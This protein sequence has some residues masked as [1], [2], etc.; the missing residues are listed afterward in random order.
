MSPSFDSPT[1]TSSQSNRLSVVVTGGASGIGLAVTSYFASQG[2]MVAVLDVNSKTGPDEIAR[3]AK[4]YP[5]S[6]ITFKW[7]DVSS[8]EGQYA[9][10]DQV[11]RE[12]G[13]R[14]DIAIAN[15][16]ISDPVVGALDCTPTE[17]PRKPQLR[18]QDINLNG[19]IYSVS[20]AV[21]YML[22]NEIGSRLPDSR[23][24]IVC[25][26][27]SAAFYPFPVSPLYS[28][29][30]AGIVGLVRSMAVRLEEP[31]IQI[32]AL[33]PGALE[34]NIAPDKDLFKHMVITPMSTLIKAVEQFVTQPS[35]T[36]EV[37][38]LNEETITMRPP[39]EYAN[40]GAEHNNKMFWKLGYA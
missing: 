25:T 14:I 17:F 15:A 38:E 23:G 4:D 16:G 5:R 9:V 39:V 37:A 21:H 24:S 32:N 18:M 6:T 33:A 3:V 40:A 35:R 11:Y 31:K 19:V 8:W 2:H 22:K 13:N 12:H 28:T 7:C 20:L 1:E 34:T 30:K 29:S 26:S 10:F 27:S 36:G